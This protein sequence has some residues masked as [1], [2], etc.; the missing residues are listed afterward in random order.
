MKSKIIGMM[1]MLLG[2]AAC[3]QKHNPTPPAMSFLMGPAYAADSAVT[4]TGTT[5]LIGFKATKGSSNMRVLVVAKAIDTMPANAI[6]TYA[7]PDSEQT[8]LSRTFSFK[9]G[10]YTSYHAETYTFKVSDE[11]GY[12]FTKS[13][14]FI[15]HPY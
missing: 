3:V 14:S 13:I 10:V 7:L 4:D 9:T 11:E 8:V 12:T 5:V 2:L 1:I 15:V 6:A